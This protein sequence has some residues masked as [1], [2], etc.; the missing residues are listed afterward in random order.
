MPTPSSISVNY[1]S[2]D[3]GSLRTDLINFAKQYHADKLAFFNDANPDIMYLEM[4]AYVGDVLSFYT[5]KTFNESFLSTALARESLFRIA[6]DL[7]F[8]ELGPTPSQTQAVL[9][10]KVPFIS[11]P[12]TGVI[13]PDPDMLVA[14]K[15]GMQLSS[16]T[17][18]FFEVMEEVD[19]A[20]ARNRQIIPNL[21]S[22]NQIVDY[23]IEKSAVAIAGITKIQRFY[24]SPDKAKP[25]LQIV[26]DDTEVIQVLSVVASPGNVFIAPADEDFINP[27]KAYLEVRTLIEGKRFVELN[28]TDQIE[29]QAFAQTT[30]RSGAFV[31]IPKRFIARRDVN[32]LVTITFGSG[33]PDFST[34]NST[35]QSFI[36]SSSFSL[37]QV[38]NNTTLGEVPPP[39]STLFIKYRVGGGTKS[40]IVAGQLNTVVSKAF[41]PTTGSPNLTT[42]Q[43]VRNSLKVRNEIQAVGGREELTNE[44]I[45]Q[46]AGKIYFAQDRGVTYEDVKVIIERMPPEFGRPFRIAY[47][48]IK[49]R[50]TNFTDMRNGLDVLINELLAQTDSVGRQVKA[51][52]INTYLDQLQNGI[53]YIPVSG[54]NQVVVATSTET[55]NLL[56]AT[57]TLWLGEKARLYIVGID[58]NG[59][60]TTVYKNPT[61]NVL[62]FPNDALKYNIRNFL[63]DKRVIGDWI[64]IV[65]GRVVNFQVDF[66]VFVDKKNKQ[67]VLTDCL[68]KMRDYFKIDNWQM[69]QPI[70]AANVM[71]ALQEIDGVINVVEVKFIN[72]FGEDSESGRLY[73]A[74]ETGRYFN[75]DTTPLSTQ[76]NKF[77]M[78]T[79][80]N[81]ILAKPDTIF[82]IK[83]PNS[84]IIGRAL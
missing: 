31:D 4:V 60:L 72:I 12:I 80:N 44:E 29:Q 38:L 11:D 62:V 77:Y 18:V 53:A 70:F 43:K 1:L 39:N 78:K 21:D 42:L 15:S 24:V 71:T 84:D 20:D 8:F 45:R 6:T 33:N 54:N 36:D 32:Q 10:I 17:G 73:A 47:E 41:F 48:E 79:V 22:N 76:N 2:R 27:D 59:Q 61:T 28:P 19:F 63:R 57:P 25:F 26:L 34:F 74:P 69:D 68:N 46:S 49:P 40:N 13:K 52:E 23:Q 30:I 14:I 58:E 9:S 75:I 66:T 35:I 7:G 50:V 56:N 83:Y 55:T 16:D 81:V 3:F 82:E 51:D 37:N 5:D 65:D 64:D 67:Q